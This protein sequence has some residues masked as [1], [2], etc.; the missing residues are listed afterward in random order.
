LA[1]VTGATDL[2]ALSVLVVDDSRHMRQ[3]VRLMLRVFG[4]A[5]VHE[6]AHAEVAVGHL[7]EVPTDIVIAD[8][9]MQPDGLEF[10]RQLRD[11]DNSP[12]PMVPVIM[13]TCHATRGVVSRAR[14]AGVNEFLAKPI[15]AKS[16]ALRMLAVIARPRPFVRTASYF[17]PCRRRHA[18]DQPVLGRR[19]NDRDALPQAVA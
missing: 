11:A 17:G 15:S 4:I 9:F 7:R 14:D 2:S 16:L 19:S 12:C 1:S 5:Q 6:A 8:L 10:V 18:E 13:M 3:L